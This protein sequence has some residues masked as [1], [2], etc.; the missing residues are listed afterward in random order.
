[1]RP[2]LRAGLRSPY[3]AVLPVFSA[4]L[5]ATTHCGNAGDGT[6]P[7]AAPSTTGD[8][9]TSSACPISSGPAPE[10][11]RDVA[12]PPDLALD[13]ATKMLRDGRNI[14]R[15]DTFGDEAFWGDTLKLP[16]AIVGAAKGG[17]G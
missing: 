15:F 7:G 16:Q 11:G 2:S 5:A 13:N 9:A 6:S 17:V 8:A 12:P 10:G 14:F 3:V 1:M 4:L